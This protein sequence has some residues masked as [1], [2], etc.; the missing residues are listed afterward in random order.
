MTSPDN[1]ILKSDEIEQENINFSS[2]KIEVE[3]EKYQEKDLDLVDDHRVSGY[4]YFDWAEWP[5]L[6]LE[7]IYLPVSSIE[8]K[9]LKET[10]E[11]ETTPIEYKPF[12]IVTIM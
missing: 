11:E 12:K 10:A 5:P 3:D 6:T 4:S 2:V 1:P 8:L 7:P 9:N